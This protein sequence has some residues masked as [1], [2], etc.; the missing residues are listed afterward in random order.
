MTKL[1]LMK[2][3]LDLLVLETLRRGPMHGY[4]I[5]RSIKEVSQDVF[6]IEEG[7]LYPALHRL[8][9]RGWVE[10][11]WGVSERNRRARYY[12]L[13]PAGQRA[14]AKEA[15]TWRRYIGA[16]AKVMNPQP[17]ESS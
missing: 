1:D 10:A 13:T 17:G 2:G 5:A 3:T 4:A 6:Q 16:V 14:L 11:D 12:Q 7:A 9:G 15:E 8:E